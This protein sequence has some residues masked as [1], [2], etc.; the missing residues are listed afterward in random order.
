MLTPGTNSGSS[1]SARTRR[2]T[3]KVADCHR[4]AEA[5]DGGRDRDDDAD[6]ERRAD[7]GDEH[8]IAPQREIPSQR[9]S[10]ARLAR[11]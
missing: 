4:G 5:E 1:M 6:L 8:G 9:H 7:G 11:A 3:R 10:A 2:G